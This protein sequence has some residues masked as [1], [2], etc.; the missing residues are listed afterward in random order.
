MELEK[1][2]HGF[3]NE[4]IIGKKICRNTYVTYEPPARYR[5]L[6]HL[7]ETPGPKMSRRM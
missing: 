6:P 3:F 5:P 2:M 1:R 7:A 4:N